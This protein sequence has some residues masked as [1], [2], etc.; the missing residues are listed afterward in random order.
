MPLGASLQLPRPALRVAP[1][2]VRFGQGPTRLDQT[3]APLVPVSPPQGLIAS[4]SLVNR[5][6]NMGNPQAPDLSPIVSPLNLGANPLLNSPLAPQPPPQSASSTRK[7]KTSHPDYLDQYGNGRLPDSVLASVGQGGHR[8]QADAAQQFQ[9]MVA[10]AAQQGIKLTITDSYRSFAEQVDLA[11]RKG[12]YSQG[13]LAA[14]PG[15][16]EHGWGL[17]I[18]A[19]VNDPR[20]Y[21][22]LRANAAKFGFYGDVPREPWHWEYRGSLSSGGGANG[23]V[24]GGAQQ[25]QFPGIPS[26][27]SPL[28]AGVT[29]LTQG[30]SQ[31][32]RNPFVTQNPYLNSAISTSISSIMGGVGQM[33][34]GGGASGGG[35]TGT[36]GFGAQVDPNQKALSMGQLAQLAYDAGFRGKDVATMVAIA[37]AESG[38]RPGAH[39][40]HGEDSRGLWQ[41]NVKAH[42]EKYG[43]LYDPLTNARAAYDVWKNSGSFNPWTVT[44]EKRG[45]P[46]RQYLGE[47]MSV[48]QQL[49]YL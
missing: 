24:P 36:A 7:G 1:R 34:G 19:N 11:K 44:H 23:A 21:E 14:E 38:G 43:D 28:A 26:I 41:V 10:A 4:P 16:S 33:M 3:R 27:A 40:P 46:Y 20:T 15:T 6:D 35:A 49:G 8:L 48:A 32:F 5:R 9:A 18:D 45:A 13:G 37:M 17:A 31:Q 29:K 22:W 25:A 42:G 39:N 30:L 12:L 47:A 2:D